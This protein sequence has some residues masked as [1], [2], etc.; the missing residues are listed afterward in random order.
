MNKLSKCHINTPLYDNNTTT[1]YNN[2]ITSCYDFEI[3]YKG[4]KHVSPFFSKQTYI[5]AEKN[6]ASIKINKKKSK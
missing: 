1:A 3:F 5:L 6:N 2:N 4:K